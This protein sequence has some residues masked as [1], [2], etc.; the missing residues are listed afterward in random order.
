M[1]AAAPPIIT[2]NRTSVSANAGCA[3]VRPAKTSPIT[4]ATLESQRIAIA[5]TTKAIGKPSGARPL[6]AMTRATMK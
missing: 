6:D 4:R 2:G 1:A 3:T 5:N